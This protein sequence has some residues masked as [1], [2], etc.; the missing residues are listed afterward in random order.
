VGTTYAALGVRL[1][2]THLASVIDIFQPSVLTADNNIYYRWSLILNPTVAG[3]FTYADVSDSSVQK[4]VGA[5]A[6]TV[7]GG[8]ELYGDFGV[9][10]VNNDNAFTDSLRLGSTISGVADTLVL[11]VTPLVGS[12]TYYSSLTFAEY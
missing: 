6:N 10:R 9:F 7:T 8:T 4:A 1:K 2:S 5:T 3:A 12:G 11:C